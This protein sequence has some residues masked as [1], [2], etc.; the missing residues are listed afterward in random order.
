MNGA[1]TPRLE[2]RVAS[3]I[4]LTLFSHGSSGFSAGLFYRGTQQLAFT[5]FDLEDVRILKRRTECGLWIGRTCYELPEG[6]EDKVA[7][8]LGVPVSDERDGAS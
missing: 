2:V 1:T 3:E 7:A 4:E 5:G 6:F 8:F